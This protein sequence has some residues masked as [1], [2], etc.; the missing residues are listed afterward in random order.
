MVKQDVIE[1][2]VLTRSVLVLLYVIKSYHLVASCFLCNLS[3]SSFKCQFLSLIIT[4]FFL[5]DLHSAQQKVNSLCKSHFPLPNMYR[6]TRDCIIFKGRQKE[7]LIALTTL[8]KDLS[9]W[10]RVQRYWL[11]ASLVVFAIGR[12]SAVLTLKVHACMD[13]VFDSCVQIKI[14]L[15]RVP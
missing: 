9:G 7:S 4:T 15:S 2:K 6:L 8:I 12:Q 1:R 11:W 13:A 14:T 10:G 5:F 3:Q